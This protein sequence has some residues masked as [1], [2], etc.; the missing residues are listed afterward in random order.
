MNA[1]RHRKIAVPEDRKTRVLIVDD[2]PIIREG[3]ARL[4]SQELDMVMAGSAHDAATA[5]TALA[6]L[7]PDVLV[8]DL[9]LPG[10][11][12]FQFIEEVRASHPALPILILSMHSE[13]VIAERALRAGAT[14]YITKA[15]APEKVLTAIRTLRNNRAYVTDDLAAKLVQRMASGRETPP[16]SS[17]SNRELQVLRLIGNGRSTRRIAAALELS[18][19][20]VETYRS[21]I[22]RKLGLRDSAELAS[23]AVRFV[24][25][26]ES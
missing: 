14:G 11:T 26:E 5:R 15:E 16:T 10:V 17:L 21:N 24:L 6:E 9:S 18:V 25:S 8:L 23:Y 12:G 19:K 20:T 1:E 2:H 22:K 7:E 3:L 13:P 4:I